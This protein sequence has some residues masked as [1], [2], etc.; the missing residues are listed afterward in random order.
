MV[1]IPY[2]CI[3]RNVEIA[4][5]NDGVQSK[6]RDLEKANKVITQPVHVCLQSCRVSA[7]S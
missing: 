1:S 5:L 3:C 6:G 2:T 7:A 4:Q